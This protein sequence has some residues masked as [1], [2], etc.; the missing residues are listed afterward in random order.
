[1]RSYV[2][3][4]GDSPAKI[5]IGFAG[6][7]K[8][9]GDLV[10][11]NPEKPFVTLGNGFR[12]FRDLHV[13]EELALPD[14]WFDGTLDRLPKEYFDRLPGPPGTIGE[15]HSGEEGD[16]QQLGLGAPLTLTNGQTFAM[17]VGGGSS[18]LTG[19]V[20]AN[21]VLGAFGGF[22]FQNVSTG[23]VQAGQ[24]WI[25]VTGCYMGTQPLGIG[26]TIVLNGITLQVQAASVTGSCLQQ[27]PPPFHYGGGGFGGGHG[28]PPPQ[29]GGQGQQQP[30][31][32]GQGVFTFVQ[33]HRIQSSAVAN[34]PLPSNM[35]GETVASLQAQF[36]AQHPGQYH[37]VSVD[38]PTNNEV[39]AVADYCG[40]NRTIPSPSQST[41][42]GVTV[43]FTYQDLGPSPA[44]TSCSP[45]SSSSSSTGTTLGLVALGLL[46]A[47]GAA[48]LVMK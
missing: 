44:G 9:A 41:F 34:G 15:P 31:H 48:Y 5:A 22:L 40:P 32:Q 26:T 45:S 18:A 46:A 17:T 12:T 8:C 1:M 37:V 25:D 23:L 2:V 33:G 43:V 10:D 42:G 47:A 20:L 7:P 14:K 16:V 36:D 30:P 35:A 38:I 11:A 28:F 27:Q 24:Q 19:Q 6:C 3:Q 29:Q 4:H 13:G 39:V 21:A